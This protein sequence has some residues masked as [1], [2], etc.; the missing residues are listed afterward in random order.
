MPAGLEEKDFDAW[1]DGSAGPGSVEIGARR[2]L[3]RSSC[4]QARQQDRGGRRPSDDH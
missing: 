4:I 1:L 3:A 2:F